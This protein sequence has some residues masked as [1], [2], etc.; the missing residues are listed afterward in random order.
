LFNREL[1]EAAMPNN[2]KKGN[3]SPPPNA[4]QLRGGTQGGTS[5]PA[6]TSGGPPG[7]TNA[8][9]PTG[10][11]RPQGHPTEPPNANKEGERRQDPQ[12]AVEEGRTKPSP[13][14]AAQQARDEADIPLEESQSGHD[15]GNP[16]QIPPDAPLP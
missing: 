13:E 7:G 16:R 5:A 1:M 15:Q 4:D 11:A 9:S 14:A 8:L 12:R 6:G 3:S 10:T 2:K